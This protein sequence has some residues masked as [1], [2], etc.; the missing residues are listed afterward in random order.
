MFLNI[1]QDYPH[2]AAENAGRLEKYFKCTFTEIAT[3]VM[4]MNDYD[5]FVF[6]GNPARHI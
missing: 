5:E 4:R 2:K 3:F 6:A 1:Y